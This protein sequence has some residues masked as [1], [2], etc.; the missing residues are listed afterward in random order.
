MKKFKFILPLLAFVMAIGMSFAFVGT[1]GE[2]YY[3]AGYVTIDGQDYD[4]NVDC[5][6]QT[7]QNCVVQIDGLSGEFTVYDPVTDEPLKSAS[8]INSIPDP[9]P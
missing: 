6:L 7:Q 4:V 5:D 3:V 8:P 9:R 1:A 2:D